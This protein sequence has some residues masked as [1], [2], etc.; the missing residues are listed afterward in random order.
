METTLDNYNYIIDIDLTPSSSIQ[1]SG[2]LTASISSIKVGDS[3]K[4]QLTPEE[5][6]QVDSYVANLT[7]YDLPGD[8]I[9]AS[10]N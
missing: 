3:E 4:W 6:E 7:V 9:G 8:I 10:Q 2:D 5:K 1:F